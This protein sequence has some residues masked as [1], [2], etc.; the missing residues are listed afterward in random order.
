MSDLNTFIDTTNKFTA[1]P[2]KMP[3]VDRSQHVNLGVEMAHRAAA[4]S[5]MAPEPI[6]AMPP[7]M[8][9]AN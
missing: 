2:D 8:P 3:V 7:I 1:A 4:Q 5:Q 6:K 9:V